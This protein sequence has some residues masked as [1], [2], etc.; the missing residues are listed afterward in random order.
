MPE[1]NAVIPRKGRW[2]PIYAG[3]VLTGMVTTLLGPLLPVIASVNGR[4][5]T[6]IGSLFTA[7]F[8]SSTISTLF[9]GPLTRRY[10]YRVPL[11]LGYATMG[12]GVASL[13]LIPWPWVMC[14]VVL[15]GVGI[16]FTIPS[17]NMLISEV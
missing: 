1:A 6:E 7:Q 15:C 14:A 3:F 11:S 9:S 17:S 10:G 13:L 4:R 12:M 2:A 16:G 8:L 5:T